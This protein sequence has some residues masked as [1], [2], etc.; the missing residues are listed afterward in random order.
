MQHGCSGIVAPEATTTT[1]QRTPMA[2]R[3]RWEVVA[4]KDAAKADSKPTSLGFQEGIIP[5]RGQGNGRSSASHENPMA[6]QNKISFRE[7]EY[8]PHYI[9]VLGQ[10]AISEER[11]PLF[12]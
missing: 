4:S 9:F 10:A 7:Q 8:L 6:R 11:F 12:M 2:F 1:P 5:A 3:L